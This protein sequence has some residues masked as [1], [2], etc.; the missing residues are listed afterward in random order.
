MKIWVD[1]TPRRT[2]GAAAVIE[3]LEAAAHDVFVTAREYG[4]TQGC[5]S[6]S[7]SRTRR[8]AATGAHRALG[9]ER[10]GSGRSAGL[11]RLVSDAA[12]PTWRS[13]TVR[14]TWRSSPRSLRIPSAQHAGLRVRRAAAP[15]RLPGRPPGAGPR[16]DPARAPAQRS[17]PRGRSWSAIRASRRSTTSP[18]SSPTRRRWASWALDRGKRPRRRPAAARDV[19]LPRPRTPSTAEVLVAWPATRGAQAVIVPR[20]EAQGGGGAGAR[21]RRS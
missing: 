10:P 18:T 14:S 8:S 5:S 16:R 6:G 21:R 7:G 17:A 11:A 13:P 12:A 9:K 1:C 4:Q 3:R 15:D 19:R 20:T 2:P